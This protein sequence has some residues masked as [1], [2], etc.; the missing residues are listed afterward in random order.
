MQYLYWMLFQRNA[1][2]QPK[3]YIAQQPRI[4]LI[5]ISPWKLMGIQFKSWQKTATSVSYKLWLHGELTAWTIHKKHQ[6]CVCK[7]CIS[8]TRIYPWKL[9][10]D[11]LLYNIIT[12]QHPHSYNF[13]F[14]VSDINTDLTHLTL[15]IYSSS[16]QN[17]DTRC[18]VHVHVHIFSLFIIFI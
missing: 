3:Y 2:T 7:S 14:T 8:L 11:V 9:G 18:H 12:T 4:S 5:F 13:V 17:Y 16:M 6:I 1:G 10:C 15:N